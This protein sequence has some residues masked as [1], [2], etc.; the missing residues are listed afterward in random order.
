MIYILHI[1]FLLIQ[2]E[3]EIAFAE[4]S[5]LKTACHAAEKAKEDSGKKSTMA[6][7]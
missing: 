1:S 3:A 2:N 6:E 7:V 5:A 4:N